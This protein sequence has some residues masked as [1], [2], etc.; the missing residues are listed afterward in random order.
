MYMRKHSQ[1]DAPI[2]KNVTVH[3]IQYTADR[4]EYLWDEIFNTYA[5]Q[6][7][8]KIWKITFATIVACIFLVKLCNNER[9]T[10]QVNYCLGNGLVP[11]GN[12][13]L[14]E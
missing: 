14:P 11:S 4:T 3:C 1:W 2:C 13:P 9:Q 12:K 5:Q 6:G 8:F 10:S 7:V